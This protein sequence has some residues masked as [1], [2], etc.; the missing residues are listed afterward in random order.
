MLEGRERLKVAHFTISGMKND[1]LRYPAQRDENSE[2]EQHTYGFRTLLDEYR[3]RPMKF[4]A[5]G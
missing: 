5:D 2:V 4:E 3:T 1:D